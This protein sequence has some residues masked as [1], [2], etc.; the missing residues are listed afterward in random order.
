MPQ[1]CAS[2]HLAQFRVSL[3]SGFARDSLMRD[4]CNRGVKRIAGLGLNWLQKPGRETV[5]RTEPR[6][7]RNGCRWLAVIISIG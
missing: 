4:D 5:G 1:G 2:N 6:E 7:L 3:P